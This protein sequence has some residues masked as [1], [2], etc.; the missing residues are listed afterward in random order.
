MPKKEGYVETRGDW[1]KVPF[2]KADRRLGLIRSA[3]IRTLSYI[4]S[5]SSAGE[6]GKA[7]VT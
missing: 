4:I 1:Q 5:T 7:K 6:K 3:R 2:K